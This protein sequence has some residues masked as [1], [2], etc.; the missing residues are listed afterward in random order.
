[1]DWSWF[2]Q[3]WL[4]IV[5]GIVLL[6]F[7]FTGWKI[8]LISGLF[9]IA[10]II[11][12]IW[13][14]GLWADNVAGLLGRWIASTTTAYWLGFAII[15]AVTL[16]VAAIVAHFV[17]RVTQFGFMGPVNVIGGIIIGVLIGALVCEA[18]LMGLSQVG[19]IANI[20]PSSSLVTGFLEPVA[21]WTV[22]ILPDNE[23]LTPVKEFFAEL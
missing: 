16:I 6:L 21:S 3:H 4:D 13:F 12:G 17:G 10:G 11:G 7:L 15:V 14:A 19:F 22:N 18:A 23:W 1:M 9:S 2:G 20:M 8:G 5:I